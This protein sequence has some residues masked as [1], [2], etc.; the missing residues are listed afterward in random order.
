MP[1]HISCLVIVLLKVFGVWSTVW[2][3]EFSCIIRISVHVVVDVH[4][5]LDVPYSLTLAWYVEGR[6]SFLAFAHGLLLSII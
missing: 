4:V 3:M 1:A 5:D 2:T 6:V